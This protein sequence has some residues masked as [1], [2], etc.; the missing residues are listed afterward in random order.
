MARPPLAADVNDHS[1]MCTI[2]EAQA[3]TR[4]LAGLEDSDLNPVHAD[5]VRAIAMKALTE[6]LTEAEEAY[7]ALEANGHLRSWRTP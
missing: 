4:L 2:R 5:A 6:A 1:V 7:R 3:T